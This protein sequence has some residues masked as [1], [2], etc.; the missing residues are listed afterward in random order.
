[1]VNW[2]EVLAYDTFKVVRVRDKYLGL[3]R[4]TLTF[5]ILIYI[6]VKVLVLDKSYYIHD[7]PGGSVR[8]SLEA[9]KDTDMSKERFCPNHPDYV[10][11]CE[12]SEVDK[13]WPYVAETCL[14]AKAPSLHHLPIA[15]QVWDPYDSRYPADEQNAIFITTRAAVEKQQYNCGKRNTN[16]EPKQQDGCSS[17]QPPYITDPDEQGV[18]FLAGVTNYTLGIQHSVFGQS[19]AFQSDT[20]R[21]NSRGYHG[22][23]QLNPKDPNSVREFPASD[24]NDKENVDKPDVI[25]V[26]E[27]L[28][29]ASVDLSEKSKDK[30][31]S[32]LYSGTVVLVL[33][34][35]SNDEGWNHPSPGEPRYE[36][37][38]RRVNN[39]DYKMF[40]AKDVPNEPNSRL[41]IKRAGPK[42]IFLVTGD[43]AQFSFQTLLIQLASA[44]GLLSVAT[45]VVETVMLYLAKWRKHY[46]AAKFEETNDFSDL[47]DAGD[48]LST[49]N[50]SSAD[51]AWGSN[52]VGSDGQYAQ[53]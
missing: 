15:C 28:F 16:S 47:Y 2:D 29:A 24:P 45:L 52:D 36:Y 46:A 32:L 9:P 14:E 7:S 27:L 23:I 25:S 40:E 10:I 26:G 41:L 35:Y 43:F 39:S 21:G 19:S 37:I 50:Q 8:I 12:Q 18:Y 11:S 44:I 1:M 31:N 3:L 6:V 53:F 48:D 49:N 22:K 13:A 17:D 38:V 5:M 4:Y 33:V 20:Y 51:G 42:F 30:S 34:K